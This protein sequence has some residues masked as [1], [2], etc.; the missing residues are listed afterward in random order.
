M[1]LN[2]SVLKGGIEAITPLMVTHWYKK[3]FFRNGR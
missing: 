3:S 1:R 2:H